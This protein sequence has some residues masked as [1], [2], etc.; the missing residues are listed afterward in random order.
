M[1]ITEVYKMENKRR[2]SKPV[3][4]GIIAAAVALMAGASVYAAAGG[5]SAADIG[6]AKAKEIALGQVP[7]ASQENI[8]KFRKDVDDSRQ[9][10][11]VE[12]IY[13]GYEYDFEISAA[14]GTIFDRSK[15]IAEGYQHSSSADS[16]ASDR[17]VTETA[18]PEPQTQAAQP[19]QSYG[20]ASSADI[21]IEKAKSTA[22]AQVSG[23]SS[24]D[25]VKA[26]RDYDDG[27]LEYGIEIYYGGYE[28]DF[29]IDG[30]TGSIISK[31]VDRADYY[32]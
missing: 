21:G 28:Y 31:D 32:D 18:T 12:I 1:E 17:L 9:E 15:D 3:K 10:Y 2:I 19:S 7:G 16:T 14:D 29:E 13:G 11:D 5:G 27:R 23:A 22:L 25:I 20:Y 6:E 4:I 24:S 26:E 30:A 8:T